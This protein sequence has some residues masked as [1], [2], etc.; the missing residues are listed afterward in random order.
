VDHHNDEVPDLPAG[1]PGG[2]VGWVT[3]PPPLKRPHTGP[4]NLKAAAATFANPDRGE[5]LLHRYAFKDGYQ[6]RWVDEDGAYVTLWLYRFTTTDDGA[7]FAAYFEKSNA[8]GGWGEPQTVPGVPGGT[9]F[10]K[11]KLSADGLQ[12]TLAIAGRGDIVAVVNAD[13]LPPAG[14]AA[15]DKVLATEVGL[16]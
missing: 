2:P 13:E 12:P 4:F 6:R 10:A 3:P 16:L 15:P 1:E 11:Q 7:D 5:L 8:A 9:A 14:T